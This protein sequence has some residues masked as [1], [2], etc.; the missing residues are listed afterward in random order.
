MNIID[1]SEV[2]DFERALECKLQRLLSKKCMSFTFF[3]K[4]FNELV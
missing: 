2:H 4:S 3:F 1:I